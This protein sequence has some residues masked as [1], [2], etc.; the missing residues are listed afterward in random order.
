MTAKSKCHAIVLFVTLF[1]FIIPDC[2][3]NDGWKQMEKILN[4]I[5]HPVFPDKDFN[6]TNYGAV[7]N[8]KT[9]CTQAFK[10]TIEAASN[11]GGGRVVVPTGEFLTGAIHLKSNINLHLS[12]GSVIKFSDDPNM[13]LP[14]VF[15]RWE[16]LECMNYSPLIYAYKQ[17]NIAITGKGTLDGN[18]ETFTF[19]QTVK[20]LLEAAGPMLLIFIAI[21][22]IL[23]GW[24]TPTEASAVAVLYSFILAVPI[25]R[26]VK[27]KELPQMLLQTG[28]TTSVV[29]LLIGT[30]MAMSWIMA[31]ENLP[32]NISEALIGKIV[33]SCKNQG[34]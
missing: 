22:G 21:G 10:K 1:C 13:Y 7:S 9:D 32:Q 6:I 15:T 31:L 18:G 34:L 12:E 8:G 26:E 14:A 29:F 23:L 28:V 33:K 24:F 3:A 27:L 25:Y 2:L 5:K 30:S 17:K 19:K 4:R 11:A 16:G 20:M